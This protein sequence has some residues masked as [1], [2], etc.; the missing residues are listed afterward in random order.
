MDFWRAV[1]ILSRH[2]WLILLSVVVT[3]AL[4]FAATRLVG[5]RYLATVHLVTPATSPL[6]ST[7][8]MLSSD[9]RAPDSVRTKQQA[10]VF[11]AMLKTPEVLKPAL[12]KLSLSNTEIRTQLPSMVKGIEFKT[13]GNRLYELQVT[14]GSPARAQLLANALADSMVDRAEA[15][16]TE[17]ASGVV[18]V[19]EEQLQDTDRQLA[20]TRSSFEG[21][22]AKHGVITN[23]S[24]QLSPAL[25]RLQSARQKR[26]DA[27]ERLAEA[28]ARLIEHEAELA[29]L[30]KHVTVE[31]SPAAGPL[32]EQLEQ[33]LAQVERNLTTLQARYTD[34]KIEVRQA[35]ATRDALQA[36]LKT[37]LAQ[38]PKLVTTGVN[39][40][41]EP[42]RK[43]IRDLRQQI[44]G[45][46]A[47]LAALNN[48]VASAD[49]EIR[50]FTGVDGPLGALAADVANQTLSRDN[51]AARLQAARMAL[52]VAGRE[53]PLVSMDRVDDFN[54]PVDTTFGRTMKLVLLAALCALIGTA[55]LVIGYDSVDRRVRTLQ[56]AELMLPAPVLTAIP[57]PLG[58]VTAG[59]LPRATELEPLSAHS[60]AYRFLGL[61]LL[62]EQGPRIR[63]LMV[64][65]AKAD[66]GSTNTVTN[67]GITLAQAGYR[68]VI[69]DANTRTPEIH[70]V[71][72]LENNFGLTDVLANFS[73][74]AV[75]RALNTTTTPNL[76]VITSGS[77]AGNLWELFRS[78]N[79]QALSTHLTD[80]VD[81]VLYDTPSAVAFTDAMNLSPVVDA[82]Y[83]CVR[84][85]EQ[86][87]GSEKRLIGL[88]EQSGVPV[89][90]SVLSDIPASVL[91]SYET[92]QRY[93]P[94]T[95]AALS[96]GTGTVAV[97]TSGSGWIDVSP[98]GGTAVI[99]ADDDRDDRRAA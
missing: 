77:P 6:T 25:Y 80:R 97:E 39:P 83:L 94:V 50:K 99:V 16:Y 44:S 65:S 48:T 62:S 18:K 82:A 32:A 24:E 36:R 3:T 89:L 46:K 67:L 34:E 55:G 98:G 73:E 7:P 51:L 85:L 60:E 15:L 19:L 13:T 88:L 31:R 92:Y 41:L 68:V 70:Q 61:H 45:H 30:P 59:V 71:F 29:K 21:F 22:R 14:D 40:E 43:A 91:E 54:P 8:G 47:Q 84:A 69:V 42:A 52:D 75:T 66:Q 5:S 90:G 78:R 1:G 76:Q 93:Y 2:K 63:S 33:E 95:P 57:Q 86:P 20:A 96:A 28:Q 56:E 11:A 27:T 72:E 10:E 64:L 87:S 38:R 53:S 12:E 26:E 17:R 79:L 49:R 58:P 9:E 23:L 4:T 74:Q 35:I 37:E 81:Y